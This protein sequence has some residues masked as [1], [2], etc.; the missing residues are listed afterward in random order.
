MQKLSNEEI[1]ELESGRKELKIE[2]VEKNNL[3][4]RK[5]QSF[6]EFVIQTIIDELN[7][8]NSRGDGM[9]LLVDKCRVRLDYESVAKKLDIPFTK[10]DTIDKLKDKI[11]EGTIGFRLRSQAI[12]D[13]SD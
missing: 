11:I 5:T 6:D 2:L 13:K 7:T 3:S 12:Q 8:K 10:K 1:A 4:N 9:K